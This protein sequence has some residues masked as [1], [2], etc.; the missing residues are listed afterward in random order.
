MGSLAALNVARVYPPG[1]R[2]CHRTA[3][4]QVATARAAAISD[5]RYEL[6]LSIPAS[7]TEPVTGSNAL[8]FRLSDT[9]QHVLIDFDADGAASAVV[10]AN[11]VAVPTRAVNGHLVIAAAVT[12]FV[13][14]LPPDYAARL[15]VKVLQSADLLMRAARP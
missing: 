3:A 6:D 14:T 10:T 13:H 7:Q 11:G 2:F 8:R 1:Q 12:R 15:R 9:A 4:P 5:L